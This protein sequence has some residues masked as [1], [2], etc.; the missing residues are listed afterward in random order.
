MDWFRH[1]HGL[2]TDP[3]LHRI[4]R[5]AKVSRGLVIAAWC[6]ILETASQNDPRGCA[7]DIDD[8]TLAF[9]VDIKPGVAGRILQAIRA[10][11]LI[12]DEGNVAAWSK[13]QRA[14]DDGAPRVAKHRA[15]TQTDDVLGKKRS[16]PD[17]ERD[18]NP[19]PENETEGDGN[20][21]NPSRTEQNRTEK[22]ETPPIAPPSEPTAPPRALASGE[23]PI[24]TD[25]PP[26][27]EPPPKAKPKPEARGTFLPPDWSP[28]DADRQYASQDCHLPD[29]VIDEQAARFRDHWTAATGANARK[30]DWSATWRNWVRR[31]AERPYWVANGAGN[32]G[33]SRP[34]GRMEDRPRGT[35]AVAAAVAARKAGLS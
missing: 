26:D 29:H 33:Y 1:Y 18:N 2:C 15:R 31:A 20:V 4:A 24:P 3:K 21:T 35:F 14:S 16:Q 22:K 23:T 28:T 17:R 27:P 19:L 12:D 8:A 11:G 32:P 9:M 30:R 13:R 34:R 25:P 6:A 5:T 10:A 7:D